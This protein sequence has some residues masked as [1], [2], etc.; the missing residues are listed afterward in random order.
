LHPAIIPNGNPAAIPTLMSQIA[1]AITAQ[2][3]EQMGALLVAL[4]AASKVNLGL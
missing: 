3:G 2:N 1:A 4:Y